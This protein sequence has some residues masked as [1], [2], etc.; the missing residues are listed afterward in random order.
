MLPVVKPD[1]Y[2]AFPDWFVTIFHSGISSA[3]I[4]AILLNLLF[5]HLTFAR[6]KPGSSVFAEADRYI[7]F[8]E[9]DA[10]ANLREG[11]RIEDGHVVDADGKPVL[12]RR[13]RTASWSTAGSS[14]PRTSTELDCSLGRPAPGSVALRA[15][16]FRRFS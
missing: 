6:Q 14:R 4:M 10:F 13:S 11:D 15:R 1:I 8:T 7:D 3:A 9:V 12:V 5:N 16:S 2:H